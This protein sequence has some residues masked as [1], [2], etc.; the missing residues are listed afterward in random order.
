MPAAANRITVVREL[1][2]T[3]SPAQLEEL[4][5]ERLRELR[6]TIDALRV[7]RETHDPLLAWVIGQVENTQTR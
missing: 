6:A 1:A 7:E 4:R 3:L 5:L 2:S